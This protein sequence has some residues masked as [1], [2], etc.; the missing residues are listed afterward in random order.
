MVKAV[1]TGDIIHSTKLPSEHRKVLL[2][3]I[4]QALKRWD[5]SFKMK[6]EMFRGDSFQC[7]VDPVYGLR[8]ALIIKTYIRSLNPS[9]L[10]DL[11]NRKNPNK[12]AAVFYTKFIYDAR[13]AVGIGQ[14]EAIGQRLA[15][16]HGPAFTTS[17]HLLD[18]IKNTR[19]SL[20]IGSNDEF[21]A[22]WG[23]ESFLLDALIAKTSAL[24]CKVLYLKLLNNTEIQIADK[25]QI[26]QSA[27]NQRS[28]GGSWNAIQRMLG[29][30]EEI[31]SHE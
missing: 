21:D 9:M 24:Q 14:I 10:Y 19:Q 13:V 7:L 6:S 20:T 2:S 5:K 31:Y 23:T 17:G 18:D 26:A 15:S 12:K 8:V 11:Q 22:E 4:E 25:L 28:T 16:S 30:F 29:R 3:D 27:V 1:I